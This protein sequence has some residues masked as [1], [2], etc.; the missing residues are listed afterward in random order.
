MLAACVWRQKLTDTP[1]FLFS[2]L[3]KRLDFDIDFHDYSCVKSYFE[4]LR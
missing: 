3:I 2:S 4:G 1:V